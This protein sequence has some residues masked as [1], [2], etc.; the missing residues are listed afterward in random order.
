STCLIGGQSGGSIPRSEM[1]HHQTPMGRLIQWIMGNPA[2]RYLDGIGQGAIICLHLREPL[3]NQAHTTVPDGPLKTGPPVKIR[4]ITEREALKKAAA[5]L[6]DGLLQVILQKGV[7][8]LWSA[9]ELRGRLEQMHIALIGCIRTEAQ[10]AAF[11][12]QVERKMR[13]RFL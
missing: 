12:K 3:E 8:R 10:G 7:G 6:I 4:G 5:I 13:V 2:R 9:E 11:N 1:E